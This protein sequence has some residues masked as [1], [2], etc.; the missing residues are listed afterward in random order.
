MLTREEKKNFLLNQLP[1]NTDC[2]YVDGFISGFDCTYDVVSKDFEQQL[3]A[4]DVE[5][6]RL[7]AEKDSLYKTI[8]DLQTA[9]TYWTMYH[10][11]NK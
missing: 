7:K 3:K 4:K 11:D 10:K 6:E 9:N 2:Y 1:P 5:I 8:M